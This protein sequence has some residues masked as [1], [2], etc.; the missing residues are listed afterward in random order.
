M[1]I[2]SP[3]SGPPVGQPCAALLTV[4]FVTHCTNNYSAI[5][6]PYM[7]HSA[8][9]E[10][11]FPPIFGSPYFHCFQICATDPE[12]DLIA[13]SMAPI[14]LLYF[15]SSNLAKCCDFSEIWPGLRQHF[16][17]FALCSGQKR[18]FP[19]SA[20]FPFSILLYYYPFSTI[21]SSLSAVNLPFCS[22]IRCCYPVLRGC[23]ISAQFSR[24]LLGSV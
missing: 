21:F 2:K 5:L 22:C 23:C 8:K 17:L 24:P 18:P 4:C 15:Y 1:T 6:Q 20:L 13:A 14:R 10:Q 9:F 3:L 19:Y 16:C 11:R 7:L 12:L